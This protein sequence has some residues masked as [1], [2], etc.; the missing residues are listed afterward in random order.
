MNEQTG[1]DR[2][3]PPAGWPKEVVLD[4]R[5]I[6]GKMLDAYVEM[7]EK[8]TPEERKQLEAMGFEKFDK[9][10]GGDGSGG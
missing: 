10:M 9:M 4:D 6:R 2:V 1:S 7:A 3:A 5:H 8:M